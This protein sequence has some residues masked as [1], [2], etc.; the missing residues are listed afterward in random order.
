VERRRKVATGTKWGKGVR[1]SGEDVKGK[2]LV[3]G[4]NIPRVGKKKKTFIRKEKQGKRRYK[5]KGTT[6]QIWRKK[7]ISGGEVASHNWDNHSRNAERQ[8]YKKF[9]G[10]GVKEWGF[11]KDEG[12]SKCK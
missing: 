12:G 3:V 1:W 9:K 5:M 8:S 6:L 2:K 11:E 7:K 4:I 10:R